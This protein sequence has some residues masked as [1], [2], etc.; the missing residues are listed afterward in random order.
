MT[1]E[2]LVERV[3]RDTFGLNWEP[4][5]DDGSLSGHTPFGSY[6]V[7]RNNNRWVWRYCFDEYYDEDTIECENLGEAMAGAEAHWLDRI[8]GY[9]QARAAIKIVGEA[10]AEDAPLIASQS[11]YG[12]KPA[13]DSTML[14]ITAIQSAILSLT[15]GTK[16]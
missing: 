4:Y 1:H 3:A 15:Q 7:G 9:D 2:E 8:D 6:S 14:T 10:L 11:E 5:G 16:E 12:A 13:T